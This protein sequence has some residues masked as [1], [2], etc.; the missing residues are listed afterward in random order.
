MEVLG[1]RDGGMLA[2]W[3]KKK[4]VLWTCAVINAGLGALA[5]GSVVRLKIITGQRADY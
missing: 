1:D 5:C 4:G 2:G 3:E